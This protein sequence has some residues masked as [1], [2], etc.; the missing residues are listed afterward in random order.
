[1]CIDP[2]ICFLFKVKEWSYKPKWTESLYPHNIDTTI[3][4]MIMSSM[5]L[6][7]HY[8]IICCQIRA[9]L[10]P[11]AQ[12]ISLPTEEDLTHCKPSSAQINIHTHTHTTHTP[13]TPP[14][15]QTQ[16]QHK[17]KHKH[18]H[19]HTTHTHPPHTHTH[20]PTHN[21]TNTNTHTHTTHKHTNTHT[22]THTNTQT[23][24]GGLQLLWILC[25]DDATLITGRALQ[26]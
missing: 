23:H 16:T 21:H 14:Q 18:T 5:R 10:Y 25:L 20:T 4:L 26:N 19:T 6:N 7:V 8:H 24:A 11:A 3:K 1:M 15:T 2:Q 22:H 13:H 9:C 17:H 12:N